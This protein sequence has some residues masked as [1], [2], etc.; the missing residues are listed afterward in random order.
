M[1]S[2]GGALLTS[3]EDVVRY[4]Q[5]Y[6]EDLLNPTDRSSVEET[7]SGDEGDDSSISGLLGGRASGVDEVRPEFLKT[8][9]VVRLS[10]LT[11]L[12]NVVWRSG[13]LPLD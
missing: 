7:E 2:A 8:L 6:F 9:D 4:C 1:C 13:A 10:W 3:T 12:Y 11:R 5:E